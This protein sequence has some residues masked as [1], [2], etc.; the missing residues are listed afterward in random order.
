MPQIV[1][2]VDD[3]LAAA[4][5]AL[6]AEGMVESRSDAVRAGLI[7]LLDAKARERTGQSIVDGYLRQPQTDDE[8]AGAD[9]AA[10]R[11]I[12]DEPW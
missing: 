1:T 7:A 3:D 9:E 6:V 4:V 2:R 12:A 11:M 5:D 10:A 8:M